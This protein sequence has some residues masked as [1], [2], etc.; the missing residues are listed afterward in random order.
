MKKK[1]LSREQLPLNCIMP[2]EKESNAFFYFLL[3]MRGRLAQKYL[4]SKENMKTKIRAH[5]CECLALQS[6][7]P[8]WVWL[9]PFLLAS[10]SPGP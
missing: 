4:R 7:C 5:L 9:I 8:P 3:K 1:I 2:K 10:G 6:S